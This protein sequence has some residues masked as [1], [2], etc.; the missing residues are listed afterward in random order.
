MV[1]S[2]SVRRKDVE[3]K[4]VMLRVIDDVSSKCCKTKPSW[5]EQVFNRQKRRTAKNE[6]EDSEE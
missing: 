1:F 3:N 6:S 4:N 5:R 2:V